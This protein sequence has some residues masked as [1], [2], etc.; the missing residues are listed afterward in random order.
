LSKTS[1][2]KNLAKYSCRRNWAGLEKVAPFPQ[3][4]VVALWNPIGRSYVEPH[5]G[6]KSYSN[7]VEQ[8]I[9][10]LVVCVVMW[11]QYMSGKVLHFKV[12]RSLSECRS[13]RLN[14]QRRHFPGNEPKYSYVHRKGHR[15]ATLRDGAPSRPGEA[16]PS[17]G[18]PASKNHDRSRASG[19][20]M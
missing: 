13:R 15:H 20:L 6:N 16:G 5:L 17:R 11:V 2:S 1:S 9:G 3:Q 14:C 10:T 19:F 18:P 4:K 12:D 8:F 7:R